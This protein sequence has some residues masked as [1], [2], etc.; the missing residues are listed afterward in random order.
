MKR[1]LPCLFIALLMLGCAAQYEYLEEEV[2]EEGPQYTQTQ[3][4]SIIKYNRM[5]FF[6]YYQQ[7]SRKNVFDDERC[8]TA[9]EY[10]WNYINWD[11]NFKYNDFP[12]AARCYTEL[13]KNNPQYS[14]SARIVYEMGVE[15]F[16]ES[17]YLHNA[18]GIIYNSRGDLEKAEYHFLKASEIDPSKTE[19]LEPLTEIY[20]KQGEWD[21]AKETCEK[22]LD[23]DPSNSTIRDRL[24]TIL[25]DHYSPEEFIAS[26]K[27]K[28][29]LEPDNVDIWLQLA[30]Q[31]QYL[32]KNEDAK[33]AVDEVLKIDGTNREALLMLGV[34]Y[35]NFADYNSA[36]NT[37]KKILNTDPN[38]IDVL[39]SVASA[40]KTL[41]QFEN[42][43]T[44]CL[45]ALSA[46]PGLGRAYLKLGE[47][48]ESAADAK[49]RG[50]NP[51]YSDKLVF[52]IAYGLFIKASISNDYSVK[53][54]AQRKLDYLESNEILPQK[55]DWFMHQNDFTPSD[56]EY[57]WIKDGWDEVGYIKQYMSQYQ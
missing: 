41:G 54:N 56:S 13:T 8:T 18:L 48:Y 42:S 30:H 4:D 16:P 7:M 20:Q 5:F 22:I 31:Y 3:I 34:I 27:Q 44:Y 57:S 11:D 45:K 51:T 10:F 53:E 14:D 50:K 46:S 33:S 38:N 36:I 21:K 52:A 35:E 40:Y 47:I 25:R 23:L 6:D 2:T 15:R 43:R 49:S 32:G 26:L 37:Y 17:D 55:S 28:L 9:L 24:E 12:Q 1:L 19:Y 39:L 29:E